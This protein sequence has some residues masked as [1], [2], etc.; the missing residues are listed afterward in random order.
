MFLFIVS[1]ILN[2]EEKV[3]VRNHV[4]HTMRILIYALRHV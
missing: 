4:R 3:G 1:G 2:E